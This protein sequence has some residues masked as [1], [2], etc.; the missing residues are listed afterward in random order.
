MEHRWGQRRQTNRSV[1]LKT[2]GGLAAQGHIR[3]VSLSGAFVVTP[4]PVPPLTRLLLFMTPDGS[5]RRNLQPVD[6]QV[7][8]CTADGIAIEWREFAH[9]LVRMLAEGPTGQRPPEQERPDEADKSATP[10]RKAR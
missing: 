7:V 2:Q 5:D 3:N 10:A 6:A 9:P 1:L 8:R 4:L